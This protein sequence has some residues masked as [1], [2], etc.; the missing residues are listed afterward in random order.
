MQV[1]L[2]LRSRWIFTS[3]NC[4]LTWNRGH[5]V[6]LALVIA[7]FLTIY[8]LM[9]EVP[10][11]RTKLV[12][13]L[14]KLHSSQYYHVKRY[15]FLKRL[16]FRNFRNIPGILPKNVEYSLFFTSHT[17]PSQLLFS[18]TSYVWICN[19]SSN[20]L[21]LK[22]V[23]IFISIGI[24]QKLC[25]SEY[26]KRQSSENLSLPKVTRSSAFFSI[27]ACLGCQFDFN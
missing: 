3:S 11:L 27:S 18:G 13:F 14:L 10:A 5:S 19:T 6:D 16:F 23:V 21:I 25:T 22:L 9:G 2:E 1:D 12:L 24:F 8:L 20:W 17:I 26:S 4:S 15:F 7:D